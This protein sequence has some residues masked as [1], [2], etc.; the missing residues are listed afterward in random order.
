MESNVAPIITKYWRADEFPF[1]L[2]PAFK[3]L[4]LGASACRA[5]AAEAEARCFSARGDGDVTCRL[6]DRDLL[7]RPQRPGD[8]FDLPRRLGRAE[9]EVAAADGSHGEDRLLRLTEPLV[10]R[11]RLAAA[12][13][14][15]AR[16]RH[17]GA[18][19]PEEM[20]RQR[21]VVRCLSHLARDPADNQVK[22]FIVENKTTPGFSVEKIQNKIAL[23][24]VQ[25][26]QITLK[27]AGYP[28]PIASRST[29]PSAT[30]H[31]CCA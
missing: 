17:V 14:G 12:D 22:G 5:M 3:A 21:A 23:K 30:P 11:A 26:G 4:N 29:R 25:N 9:A 31:E 24:V 2:L 18:Q 13:N 7:R 16:W 15:E 8:G 20:D 10:A 6:L 28:K 27:T 1:E 19:R